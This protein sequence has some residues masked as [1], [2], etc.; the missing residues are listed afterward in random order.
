MRKHPRVQST[1]AKYFPGRNF[2][3][4]DVVEY[5]EIPTANAARVYELSTGTGLDDSGDVWGVTVKYVRYG[6]K[7]Q[8]VHDQ[9]MMF[10]SEAD[11]RRYIANLKR[12]RGDWAVRLEE[13]RAAIRADEINAAIVTDILSL[14]E[15]IDPND[16]ELL[17]LLRE[18]CSHH[19]Q[20]SE[21]IEVDTTDTRGEHTTYNDRVMVCDKCG[22]TVGPDDSEPDYESDYGED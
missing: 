11:A 4:P 1:L 17:D 10:F 8:P 22:I 14:A 21:P 6:A 13:I 12:L 7:V 9:S 5:G 18:V 16:D 20:H 19:D 15:H 3:T 2:I